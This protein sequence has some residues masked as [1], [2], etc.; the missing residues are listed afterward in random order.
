MEISNSF[1]KIFISDKLL[2]NNIF[3]IFIVLV[4]K[5][6]LIEFLQKFFHLK[7]PPMLID[8]V[9]FLLFYVLFSKIGRIVQNKTPLSLTLFLFY[10]NLFT[11]SILFFSSF[12]YL[13]IFSSIINVFLA[14]I[15]TAV[16][17]AILNKLYY[18]K[19][20]NDISFYF[21]TM[22]VLIL[23]SSTLKFFS[24]QLAKIFPLIQDIERVIEIIAYI[25]IIIC[26]TRFSWSTFLYKKEK[27]FLIFIS[28]LIIAVSTSNSVLISKNNIMGSVFLTAL[29]DYVMFYAVMYYFMIFVA[30]LFTLPAAD[31]I[32]EKKR[33]LQ[34]L[35]K[36]SHLYSQTLSLDEIFNNITKIFSEFFTINGCWV[37]KFNIKIRDFEIISK[38]NISFAL[39]EQISFL[40]SH[41]DFKNEFYFIKL[42]N[43]NDKYYTDDNKKIEQINI[44]PIYN[45]QDEFYCLIFISNRLRYDEEDKSVLKAFQDYIKIVIDNINLIK[46]SIEKERIKKE[47]EI[48]QEVQQKLLPEKLPSNDNLEIVAYY[49]PAFEVGGDYYDFFSNKDNKLSII[50]SDVSGKGI[51]A[52]F[53]MSEIKGIFT[54]LSEIYENP[55]EILLK[56]NN[57]IKNI[58][59]KNSFITA[60]F[61]TID[62]NQD[63]L[64][65]VRAGHLPLILIRNNHIL[66]YQPKGI[67]LGLIFNNFEK[68]LEESTLNLEDGDIIFL[69]T[70]GVSEAQN[71]NKEIIKFEIIEKQLLCQTDIKKILD[72]ILNQINDFSDGHQHD[73]I[74]IILLKY[75]KRS[76]ND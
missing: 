17:L 59:S 42:S 6:F 15:I 38:E 70:D 7:I 52:S 27:I 51:K 43:E 40:V 41:N 67:G 57:L 68:Y 11:L 35:I 39:A 24:P 3:F 50:I 75:K 60:T 21:N 13:K 49:K 5:F 19:Q 74:T 18:T 66:K 69:M 65:F 22:Y 62:F 53:I 55:K 63:K 12:G 56:A 14:L 71:K 31:L 1:L 34:T 54:V 10:T 26:S 8:V 76:R 45:Y 58:I 20:K 73:D 28:I 64:N 16:N 29:F 61:L 48:A 46:E 2:R 72:N 33:E 9:L 23:V 37:A 4:I 30:T 25:S 47:L 32:E 36:F 44:I